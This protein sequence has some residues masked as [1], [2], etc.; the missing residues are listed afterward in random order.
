[1]TKLE[2]GHEDKN[3]IKV[4]VSITKPDNRM[5]SVPFTAPQNHDS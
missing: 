3:L 5:R 4:A 2:P 1:M